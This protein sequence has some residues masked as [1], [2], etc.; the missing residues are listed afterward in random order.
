MIDK[1]FNVV[2]L[3][4]YDSVIEGDSWIGD[5]CLVMQSTLLRRCFLHS[6][7]MI[8]RCAAV[9][10]TGLVDCQRLELSVGP[11]SD[12]SHSSR[13]ILAT[14]SSSYSQVVKQAFSKQYRNVEEEKDRTV[15]STVI[16]AAIL[17]NCA[18]VRNCIIGDPLRTASTIVIDSCRISNCCII[19]S[20]SPGAVTLKQSSL[21]RCIIHTPCTVGDNCTL[22][23][24]LLFECSS[25]KDGAFV[26]NAVIGP[27]AGIAQGECHHSLL[28]PF[29]GFHHQSLLIAT[30]WPLGRG[31][32]GYGAMIGPHLDSVTNSNFSFIMK[33]LF[34]QEQTTQIGRAHV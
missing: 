6:G 10:S 8:I 33:H 15:F 17:F 7:C 19:S 27:D 4:L 34:S 9:G 22:E 5:N 3:G 1:T 32:L 13:Y 28:G 14:V 26:S 21:E 2:K 18:E 23:R 12:V 24:V 25:V 30:C 20:S 31:N 11:E 16:A 29:V